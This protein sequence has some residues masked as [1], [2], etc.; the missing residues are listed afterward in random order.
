MLNNS[1]TTWDLKFS[2]YRRK[3]CK[4]SSQVDIYKTYGHNK[5][6]YGDINGEKVKIN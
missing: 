5:S 6:T 4:P 2:K 1:K 3:E